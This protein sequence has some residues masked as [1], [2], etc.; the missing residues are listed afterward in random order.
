MGFIRAINYTDVATLEA[1][2]LG[3]IN[4][5]QQNVVLGPFPFEWQ[6]NIFIINFC[7]TFWGTK[8]SGL[9]IGEGTFSYVQI[10]GLELN[11][12]ANLQ[13]GG[14]KPWNCA[15]HHNGREIDVFRRVQ[16]GQ[17]MTVSCNHTLEAN[18]VGV[19]TVELIMTM[20]YII[21]TA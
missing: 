19:S 5:G 3:T 11:E 9:S 12:A 15:V 21:E 6:Q 7:F 8:A 18:S 1:N 14:R 16:A 13:G 4:G 2:Y 20:F 17:I 10:D